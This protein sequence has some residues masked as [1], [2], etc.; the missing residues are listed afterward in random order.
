MADTQLVGLAGLHTTDGSLTGGIDARQSFT[1]LGLMHGL[2]ALVVFSLYERTPKAGE[3]VMDGIAVHK[4][5]RGQGIGSRLL[6]RVID[7]A[8][9]NGYATIRLDVIDT[10]PGA[11]R[12]YERRG[13]VAIR[14]ERFPY[15][16][17]L[18]GFGASTTMEFRI[19][20]TT[21]QQ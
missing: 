2:R 7:Y 19:A 3:L 21:A 8:R 6:R 14:V 18:L 10:N 15:L 12:L 20:D 9:E 17:W 5:Y 1:N 13:F 4:D 16:R 11:Q